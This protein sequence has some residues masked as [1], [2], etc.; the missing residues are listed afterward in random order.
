MKYRWLVLFGAL[1]AVVM[2]ASVPVAGQAPAAGRTY[3]APRTAWGDPDVQGLWRGLHRVPFERPP[4]YEGR[5]FLTDAEVAE[6]VRE[7]EA[8]Q[9]RTLAGL[10]TSTG[11]RNQANYNGIVNYSADPVRFSRRTSAIID[12]P[13]GRLPPWSLEGINRYEAREEATLGRGEADSWLDRFYGERC[14]D[15]VKTANVGFWGMSLAGE[16]RTD[17]LAEPG[18]VERPGVEGP[19]IRNDV[20]GGRPTRIMQARGYVVITHEDRATEYQIIPLDRPHLGPKFKQWMGDAR[21]HWEGDTLV[22]ETTNI[23]FPAPL[24][25]TY[26]SQAN[27]WYPGDGETL[28]ITERFMRVGPDTIEYKYTVEDPNVY[29]R[30]YTVLHELTRDDAYKVSAELCHEGHDDMPSSLA[31]ARVDEENALE[32][33]AEARRARA[34]RLKQLKE[35]AIKAA[36]EKKGR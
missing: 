3:T 22:V 20:T 10:N 29:S 21:G 1:V 13:D 5:E 26:I 16:A 28:R 32:Y 14:I 15:V 24:I 11:F 30:P 27:G 12:P 4:Q 8:G 34:P 33:A 25:P 19:R 17:E 9:A 7:A 35:G 23:K 18:V 6:L 36:E 2:M 31:A